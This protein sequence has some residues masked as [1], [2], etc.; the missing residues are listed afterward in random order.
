VALTAGWHYYVSTVDRDGLLT[1]YRD[2]LQQ[3]TVDISPSAANSLGATCEYWGASRYSGTADALSVAVGPTALHTGLL[4][5]AQM[6]DS[7]QRRHVQLLATTQA[8]YD[9][10]G[11]TGQTGWDAHF[12]N[13]N[14]ASAADPDTITHIQQQVGC[15]GG[16]QFAATASTGRFPFSF[17]APIGPSGFVVVPDLSGNDRFLTIPTIT[18]YGCTAAPITN[19]YRTGDTQQGYPAVGERAVAT[20]GVVPFFS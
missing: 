10:R 15:L 19:F 16:G 13:V 4:S 14:D 8:A 20:F 1:V 7:F 12:S 2:T 11:I 6:G 9:W 5:A 3:V 17:A 18:A